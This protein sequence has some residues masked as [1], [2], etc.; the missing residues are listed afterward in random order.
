[1]CFGG[2]AVVLLFPSYRHGLSLCRVD[3]INKISTRGLGGGGVLLLPRGVFSLCDVVTAECLLYYNNRTFTKNCTAG[4]ISARG[5]A[6]TERGNRSVFVLSCFFFFFS[7]G[8]DPVV[9]QK[10]SLFLLGDCGRGPGGYVMARDEEAREKER[11]E[12]E[13]EEVEKREGEEVPRKGCPSLFPRFRAAAPPRRPLT[14]GGCAVV[15]P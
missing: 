12:R 3:K 8:R 4:G 1:M 7:V 2:C 14:G 13:R 10:I 11:G 9:S 6:A 5:E 15:F